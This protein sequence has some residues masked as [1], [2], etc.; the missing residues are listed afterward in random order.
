M[1]GAILLER[2][3]RTNLRRAA[4]RIAAVADGDRAPLSIMLIARNQAEVGGALA[5]LRDT[6]SGE[7]QEI[8]NRLL[9][10]RLFVSFVR[11]VRPLDEELA[12]QISDLLPA[13]WEWL[14][15]QEA[16]G[17][18]FAGGPF[19]ADDLESYP[20]DGMIVYRAETLQEAREIAVGDPIV[21]AGLR[22]VDVR[23]WELNEGR[24]RISITFS[25]GTYSFD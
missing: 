4:K 3:C 8:L 25:D 21:V 19:L 7:A 23:P 13:H 20:G 2:A 6:M 15:A 14:F 22:T 17:R 16:Q 5:D 9:R 18:V 12:Q 1:I 11:P 24:L 10:K